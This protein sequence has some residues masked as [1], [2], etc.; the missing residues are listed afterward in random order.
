MT[1]PFLALTDSDRE[2]MLRTVGVGS[3]EELFG[4]LP[5][6]VRLGRELELEPALSE[7]ELF[8][9][10]ADGVDRH[11]WAERRCRSDAD[12]A[13]PIVRGDARPTGLRKVGVIGRGPEDGRR[14]DA[15]YAL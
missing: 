9:H 5:E 8:T 1:H 10:V 4:D 13:G 15:G 12:P 11:R 2:E 3:V 14:R 6:G 7:Q